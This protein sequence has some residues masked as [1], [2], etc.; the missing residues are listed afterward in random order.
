MQ[1][2]ARRVSR[3]ALAV[4][5][6]LLW[7]SVGMAQIAPEDESARRAR[8]DALFRET[9][10]NPADL[11]ATFR[12]AEEATAQGDVEAAIGA[13]ERILYFNNQLARVHLELGILYF[14]LGSYALARNHLAAAVS[15]QD[16]PEDVRRRVDEF[17]AEADR[18]LQRS[19][20]DANVRLGMRYQTNAN[21]APNGTTGRFFG[22][23]FTLPSGSTRIADWNGFFQGVVRHVY[24]LQRQ[25]GEYVETNVQTYYAAQI[26]VPRFNIGLIEVDSG[27]RLLLHPGLWPR[28]TIRPYVLAGFVGLGDRPYVS[29]FGA[30]ST[31]EG[32][33]PLAVNGEL[34]L[35]YRHREFQNTD[36]NPLVAGQSGS[37]TLLSG[38]LRRGLPYDLVAT[39]RGTVGGANA[40]DGA[41]SF[42]LFQIDAGLSWEFDPPFVRLPARPTL[43]AGM[44]YVW[45]NYADPNPLYDPSVKR[46]DRELRLAAGLDVPITNLFGAFVQVL[47]SKVDSNIINFRTSN[48]AVSFGPSVRF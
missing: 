21:I 18:R 34:R 44:S 9:L 47:Y 8:L 23:D 48:F 41:Y 11:D 19:R 14:R 16:V 25:S 22:I 31:L 40:R 39:L 37:L 29:T 26:R 42:A 38:T 1:G 27:P 36:L 4:A 7:V 43:S 24:D 33:L 2:F 3:A 32:P 12:Y 30:G 46:R 20:F 10:R 35:E 13:L 17:L 15:G 5:A 28:T 6:A 45:T